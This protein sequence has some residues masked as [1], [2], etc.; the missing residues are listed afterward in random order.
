L[1]G[2]KPPA[3]SGVIGATSVW[4]FSSTQYRSGSVLWVARGLKLGII[5]I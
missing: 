1:T 2:P 4:P 3:H 5:N